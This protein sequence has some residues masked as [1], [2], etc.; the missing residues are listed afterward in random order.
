MGEY[1]A[2]EQFQKLFEEVILLLRNREINEESNRE[3]LQTLMCRTEWFTHP[4]MTP[5]MD[6]MPLAEYMSKHCRMTLVHYGLP[7]DKAGQLARS[8][9]SRSAV[10]EAS[11]PESLKHGLSTVSQALNLDQ[12]ACATFYE[13]LLR[14]NHRSGNMNA[15]V[16]AGYHREQEAQLLCLIT[17]LKHM[18]M[19][20]AALGVQASDSDRFTRSDG[21]LY[22]QFEFFK[23]LLR[24]GFASNLVD[25]LK[26]AISDAINFSAAPS[27]DLLCSLNA[28]RCRN[29]I[30]MLFELLQQLVSLFALE[31]ET[32]LQM[33]W[34]VPHLVDHQKLDAQIL[35]SNSN[36]PTAVDYDNMLLDE[37]SVSTRREAGMRV[38]NRVVFCVLCALDPAPARWSTTSPA[39]L[40]GP[41]WRWTE[42]T[43]PLT[44]WF[45]KAVKE[46]TTVMSPAQ[47][48]WSTDNPLGLLAAFVVNGCFSEDPICHAFTTGLTTSACIQTLEGAYTTSYRD[49]VFAALVTS[50]ILRCL[51][52][53][54][55]W[56]GLGQVAR[57]IAKRKGRSASGQAANLSRSFLIPL[58]RLMSRVTRVLPEVAA[59]VDRSS[60]HSLP[61]L[62]TKLI[63]ENSSF[64][65]TVH[66]PLHTEIMNLAGCC[67]ARIH[68]EKGAGLAVANA[69]TNQPTSLWFYVPGSLVRTS[70]MF[71][72]VVGGALH[73]LH[74]HINSTEERESFNKGLTHSYKAILGV[75]AAGTYSQLYSKLPLESVFDK[76]ID[77]RLLMD[78][79][80]NCLKFP[81][82]SSISGLN[83]L[84]MLNIKAAALE[85]LLCSRVDSPAMMYGIL[86]DLV[87]HLMPTLRTDVALSL[88]SHTTA[89]PDDGRFAVTLLSVVL[90]FMKFMGYRRRFGDSLGQFLNLNRP[91][92][93]LDKGLE[94]AVL[95]LVLHSYLPALVRPASVGEDSASAPKRLSNVTFWRLCA[96]TT[97]FLSMIL[98]GPLP[99][100]THETSLMT[101]ASRECFF[102]RDARSAS[103]L[104]LA[105][106]LMSTD[107]VVLQMILCLTIA[108]GSSRPVSL[109]RHNLADS[110]R[111]TTH[112]NC[113]ALLRTMFQR[114]ALFAA[115]APT[116]H[117]TRWDVHL[118]EMANFP[119]LHKAD[120]DRLLQGTGGRTYVEELVSCSWTPALAHLGDG[121]AHNLVNA[122]AALFM[123]YQVACRHPDMLGE[124]C[125]KPR[126][127]KDMRNL[128]RAYQH[129][130]T[131]AIEDC[132]PVL[133]IS[134]E[135]LTD[136]FTHHVFAQTIVW[137]ER[138][139][140][141][142]EVAEAKLGRA[143]STSFSM[144]G[145][146][147]SNRTGY[148]TNSLM[149]LGLTLADDILMDATD[150]CVGRLILRN[151]AADLRLRQCLLLDLV[152]SDTLFTLQPTSGL[153]AH[154]YPAEACEPNHWRM[155]LPTFAVWA[156][157]QS[158]RP[159]L[160]AQKMAGPS[161]ALC[162]LGMRSTDHY[163]PLDAGR[164]LP[165][166]TTSVPLTWLKF[167]QEEEELWETQPSLQVLRALINAMH[168]KP[169]APTPTCWKALMALRLVTLLL[170]SP[171][172][173][174]LAAHIVYVLFPQ[175]FAALSELGKT[176]WQMLSAEKLPVL[177]LVFAS[178]VE[179]CTEEASAMIDV[180]LADETASSADQ[181]CRMRIPPWVVLT[182]D[183]AGFDARLRQLQEQASV[184]HSSL[185]RSLERDKLLTDCHV[186][187]RQVGGQLERLYTDKISR[188]RARMNQKSGAFATIWSQ[189][190]NHHL[191]IVDAPRF[192][193]KTCVVTVDVMC[194][195][196][197]LLLPMVSSG[198]SV[199]TEEARNE[200]VDN[201]HMLIQKL[202]CQN[203]YCVT[204]F[205]L[206]LLNNRLCR[207]LADCLPMVDPPR[208]SR[209]HVDI[210]Q[211]QAV[212]LSRNLIQDIQS[213]LKRMGK[214]RKTGLH[215]AQLAHTCGWYSVSAVYHLLAHLASVVDRV[216]PDV[217]ENLLPLPFWQDLFM[218]LLDV[219]C[220]AQPH[221]EVEYVCPISALPSP[222]AAC[223]YPAILSASLVCYFVDRNGLQAD[224]VT[225]RGCSKA[226]NQ[227]LTYGALAGQ[228]SQKENV[229]PL[230]EMG[231]S[232]AMGSVLLIFKSMIASTH[233]EKVASLVES[234]LPKLER[235]VQS[236]MIPGTSK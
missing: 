225:S 57:Q 127:A 233:S 18:A 111:H 143:E 12:K 91:A 85:L 229:V 86:R 223:L 102:A 126:M 26:N 188:I 52:K 23:E 212:E 136:P 77:Y 92:G 13:A 75:V 104:H 178:L 61:D 219:I 216:R 94:Q 207:Y 56:Q 116:L 45:K 193:C 8:D 81:T 198:G 16:V 19:S 142:K 71:R 123:V 76:A 194:K 190:E 165:A 210:Q 87:D 29:L 53:P 108:S 24:R 149:D 133:P 59:Q 119:L 158:C 5:D 162:L 209:G 51:V 179:L 204:L 183:D 170:A 214:T 28:Q 144:M 125:A 103:T 140:Y 73:E 236:C 176:N 36:R 163:V 166:L 40:I 82:T 139:D 30:D 107:S 231:A 1:W 160:E 196:G 70:D 184:V 50:S 189:I 232:Y 171:Q 164:Q 34:M 54:V 117:T 90:T 68:F 101:Q 25:A 174:D 151:T 169:S 228:E 200:A 181:D 153:G 9:G 55:M 115:L 88:G 31:T 135:Q 44:E 191:N 211:D 175:R 208:I 122:R 130:M 21:D 20:G 43:D 72:A 109:S 145:L 100:E 14:D 173:K 17:L 148:F 121:S 138:S 217:W 37:E 154:H 99:T 11:L 206:Q 49:Q 150:V 96:V 192:P 167:V 66:H 113:L 199:A 137:L 42:S 222:L 60:L 7:V 74:H 105:E 129:V 161:F 205:G 177:V 93:T 182:R 128:Q 27:G 215:P 220:L 64:T 63:S 185:Y 155:P 6:G 4:L 146:P 35:T 202:R 186:V 226:V 32:V 10:T 235:L 141:L 230:L 195:S 95:E 234:N 118:F 22:V 2:S 224:L 80:F 134:Y 38:S 187:T 46:H 120:L 106:R 221:Q 62:Y 156:L 39:K 65:N 15:L 58:I 78:T 172:T 203:S 157:E 98:K 114:D 201:L 69:L 152:P 41:R 110:F 132:L 124:L 218:T 213:D 33:L 47:E 131:A 227:M 147:V 112:S 3:F 168:I 83:T 79:S 67:L 48:F 197:S 84:S 159:T 97:N 180:R 89:P